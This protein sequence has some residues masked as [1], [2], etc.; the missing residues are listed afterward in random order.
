MPECVLVVL[1]AANSG[2]RP[3]RT[4]ATGQQPGADRGSGLRVLTPMV[5]IAAGSFTMGSDRGGGDEQPAH[6]VTLDA[7]YLDKYLVTQESYQGL[8]WAKT[9]ARTRKAAR[10]PWSACAGATPSRTAMPA[11]NAMDSTRAIAR[12]SRASGSATSKP[13]DTACRPRRNGS[14]PAV[15][16]RIRTTRFG[17]SGQELGK[18]AWY[19][20]NAG[21]QT[22]RVGQKQPNA[23]GLHD[24]HG[25]VWE[26]V[27]DFYA[28]EFYKESPER[29]PRGPKS[30]MGLMRGGSFRDSQDSCRSSYRKYND[31]E[32]QAPVCAA[33]E[34]LGF[35]CARACKDK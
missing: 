26:W 11:R 16:E 29:N 7:F 30:G 33:Y 15:R 5:R 20:T 28:A 1:L 13:A 14:T 12:S 24:M 10:T 31:D 8:A 17:N 21:N 19:A 32:D 25:N 34:H 35:R 23:W 18:Y 4:P 6:R 2:C 9:P 27:N 22:H 3:A